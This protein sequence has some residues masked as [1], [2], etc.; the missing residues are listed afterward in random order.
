MP[1]DTWWLRILLVFF[2][3]NSVAGWTMRF[4]I[5]KTNSTI[6]V[7][8]TGVLFFVLFFSAFSGGAGRVPVRRCWRAQRNDDF[9]EI[10]WTANGRWVASSVSSPFLNA[11]QSVAGRARARHLFC[12]RDPRA[13]A[14]GKRPADEITA[15]PRFGLIL[16]KTKKKHKT[17]NQYPQR[18]FG[19]PTILFLI[20]RLQCATLP[21]CLCRHVG[22]GG[23]WPHRTG[24]SGPHTVILRSNRL[25]VQQKKTD[26]E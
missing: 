21:R 16:S 17:K 6:L 18:H 23:S 4:T 26:T 3:Q 9:I 2:Y 25:F 10:Y 20:K 8:E 15:T 19:T 12:R 13:A 22:P 1:C 11:A 7:E 14:N 24:G 5:S